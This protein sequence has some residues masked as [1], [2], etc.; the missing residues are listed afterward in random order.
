MTVAVAI[1]CRYPKKFDLKQKHFLLRKKRP[2]ENK[3]VSIFLFLSFAPLFSEARFSFIFLIYSFLKFPLLLA[4]WFDCS[5]LFTRSRRV[6]HRLQTP[7]LLHQ[8][9]WG[10]CPQGAGE[11]SSA[12]CIQS[13]S[14][15]SVLC[16]SV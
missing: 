14:C 7:D 1:Q 3:S 4:P 6:R 5:F 8:Y 12:T 11:R 16:V 13:L 15:P 9:P 10:Q 2:V